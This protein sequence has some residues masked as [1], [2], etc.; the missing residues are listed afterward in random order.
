MGRA[1]SEYSATRLALVAIC[2]ATFSACSSA[3]RFTGRGSPVEPSRAEPSEPRTSA[4]REQPATDA[5]QEY[6]FERGSD[7]VSTP[8]ARGNEVVEVA[9][10]Y[11]G[12]PYRSGGTTSNGVDCS[13]LTVAVY[14]EVGVKLPR[15]SDEQARVGEP[16]SRDHLAPGDLIFFGSS[17]NVSHVGIYKGDGEF[18]H[19]STSARQVRFD[20]L[21][22][23]YF[24][25]RYVTARR[26]M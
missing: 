22:S 5:V 12:T 3:P 15:N 6:P 7:S 26:V 23:K 9:E 4:T 16:V 14:R 2:A 25:N 13:G 19:A 21:D 18:I 10:Q 8:G 1:L 11:L 20:R 24:A 17:G